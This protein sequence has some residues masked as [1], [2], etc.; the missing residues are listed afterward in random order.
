MSNGEK[1]YIKFQDLSELV[2]IGQVEQEARRLW[3]I[4]QRKRRRIEHWLI[5]ALPVGLLI[6]ACVFYALSAPH[7]AYI[8]NLITPGWGWTAPIGFELGS[9]SAYKTIQRARK[10]VQA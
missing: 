3:D 7:T 8:I 6:M 5:R 9:D 1:K 10:D 4:Q 2:N